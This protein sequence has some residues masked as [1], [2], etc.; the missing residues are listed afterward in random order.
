MA[1]VITVFSRLRRMFGHAADRPRLL[2]LAGCGVAAF[3]VGFVLVSPPVAERAIVAGGYYYI[4]GVFAL[5]GYFGWRVAARRK[6][7]WAGWMRRPGWVGAALAAALVFTIWSD[8]FRHKVLFDEYVLQ[9][10][11]WHMHA[12]KEIGTPIRAYDFGGTWLAID[13]FLDKRPYFFTFLVSLV[14]DVSG[15]RLENAFALNVALALGC[16][17]LVYWI[18][19]AATGRRGPALLALGLLASAEGVLRR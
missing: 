17:A 15:Y 7:V 3:A 9:G 19:H 5:F 14:H 6:E 11:A 12:T 2:A 1:A 8:A 13:T 16:L 10:T 4:G 18:V